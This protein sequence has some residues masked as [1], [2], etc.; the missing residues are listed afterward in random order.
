M[1]IEKLIFTEE[2]QKKIQKAKTY[3]EIKSLQGRA[4]GRYILSFGE[5]MGYPAGFWRKY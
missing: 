2:E 3:S 4:K 5:K 1:I